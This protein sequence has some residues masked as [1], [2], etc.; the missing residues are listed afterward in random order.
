MVSIS[1]RLS[2]LCICVSF[3]MGFIT[4]YGILPISSDSPTPQ[5]LTKAY[6]QMITPGDTYQTQSDLVNLNAVRNGAGAFANGIMTIFTVIP[7]CIRY[8]VPVI[9]IALIQGPIWLIYGYD[10][11]GFIKGWWDPF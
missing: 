11:L 2:L 1:A 5:N 4:D 8:G 7:L 6:N 3:M 10:V 9:Y